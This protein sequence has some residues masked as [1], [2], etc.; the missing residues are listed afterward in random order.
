MKPHAGAKGG[1][2]WRNTEEEE[3]IEFNGHERL[4]CEEGIEESD[5]ENSQLLRQ[6]NY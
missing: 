2:H 6:Y 4:I 5:E 1:D 3:H